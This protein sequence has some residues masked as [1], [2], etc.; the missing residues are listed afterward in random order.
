M[1]VGGPEVENN[2]AKVSIIYV[3][4]REIWVCLISDFKFLKLN[5]NYWLA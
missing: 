1:H 2:W 4:I 3:V 5:I